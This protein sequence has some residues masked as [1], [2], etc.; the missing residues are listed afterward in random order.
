MR[1]EGSPTTLKGPGTNVHSKT[2]LSPPAMQK[3]E[4]SA[5]YISP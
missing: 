5:D 1:K 2:L 3:D 4:P